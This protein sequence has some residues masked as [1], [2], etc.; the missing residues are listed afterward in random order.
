MPKKYRIPITIITVFGA[1]SLLAVT[2]VTALYLGFNQAAQSTRQLW[3]DQSKTLIDAME[4][5]LDSR[6]KPI[7]AQARWVAKDIRDLS[8]PESL[9]EYIFGTLA[10]TPQVAGV[11]IVTADGRSRRWLRRARVAIDEDWSQRPEIVA[12]IEAVKA[13]NMAAWRAPIW[14][15]SVTMATLLHDIPLHNDGGEFIGVFA[16]IIPIRELSGFLSRTY[17][18]TGVTPFVLYDKQFVLVHPTMING[19]FPT[20]TE[21]PLPTIDDVGDVILSRLWTPDESS[22]FISDL[23]VDTKASGVYWGDH[24]YLYLYRNIN[25]YGPAAWTIGAYIN[26]SIISDTETERL[27]HALIAGLGVLL[28]AIVAAIAVGRKVSAPITAI[29]AAADAVNAGQLQQIPLLAGSRIRELDEASDAFNNMVKG[30]RERKLIRDT[31][32]RFVPREVASSLLA[33]GGDIEP[34]QTA[35]TILFCDIE[36]FTRLT[37]SLGAVKIV[38]VL[39]AYFSSMVSILEAH[40]G[41]V[42]QFQGDAILATFNVPVVNPDHAN[43]ALL[44]AR[45]MLA[46][47]THI[48]FA[49]EKLNIRI[50]INTGTVVAGA[51]GAEGRLSYTVHGDA[52]NLAARLEAMNKEYGTRLL[53]SGETVALAQGFTFMQVGEATVR[54]QSR[55]IEMYT[56][57]HLEKP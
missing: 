45:D 48:K 39:N 37:E 15:A 26:T 6:L 25:R 13:Q 3:A 28:I 38:T 46:R 52:V 50:G 18:D 10:A 34:R 36:S 41:V 54:G 20:A 11:A 56:I 17:T 12:W 24:Y 8:D 23:M 51:I 7:R 4:Q 1:S 9:D 42:T 44:A 21:Q 16:Q 43:N 32:G 19:G 40:D 35:A 27:L 57:E 2:V 47:V 5:S 33:G 22:P 29:A 49:G 53:V 31:L 30:L 14:E 55:L